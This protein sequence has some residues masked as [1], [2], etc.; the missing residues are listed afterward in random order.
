MKEIELKDT[1]DYMLS[2]NYR[3]RL[4]AEFW[5]SLIRFKKCCSALR[6]WNMTAFVQE[7]DRK[8]IEH[9]AELLAGYI[10]VLMK[11]AV[12]EEID[13][14]PLDLTTDATVKEPIRSEDIGRGIHA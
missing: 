7:T 6:I 3:D 11:R 9:Q 10:F 5:Q 13:L 4:I 2:G 1:V 14:F 8:T 12:K